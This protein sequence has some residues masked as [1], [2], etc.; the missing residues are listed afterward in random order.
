MSPTSDNIFEKVKEKKQNIFKSSV[1]QSMKQDKIIEIRQNKGKIVESRYIAL[2]NSYV[3][4]LVGTPSRILYT[5][6][7]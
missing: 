4:P 3:P 1:L 5:Y 7:M 2:N 6:L